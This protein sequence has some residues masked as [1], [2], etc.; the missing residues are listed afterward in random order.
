MHVVF[1]TVA[2]GRIVKDRLPV[3]GG[4]GQADVF[5]NGSAEQLCTG[6]QRVCVAA[7]TQELTNVADNLGSEARR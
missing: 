5:A 4:L 1:R 2:A 7:V 6:P 3:T